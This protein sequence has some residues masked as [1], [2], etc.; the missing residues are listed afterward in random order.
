MISFGEYALTGDQQKQVRRYIRNLLEVEPVPYESCPFHGRCENPICPM[1]PIREKRIWYSDEGLCLNPEYKGDKAVVSQKKIA[2][3]HAQG[4]FTHAMLNRDIIVKKG[5]RG[6][7][8]DIPESVYDR[9]RESIDSLYA[10][11]EEAWIGA[12]PELTR[13]QREK[14]KSRGMKGLEALRRHGEDVSKRYP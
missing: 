9:G 3:K 12:H 14:M 1:D 13:K 5:I 11:R 10:Q 7:D 4:Y 2:K 8:P 6:I